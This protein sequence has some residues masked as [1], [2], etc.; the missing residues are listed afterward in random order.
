MSHPHGRPRPADLRDPASRLAYT[1][2][3]ANNIDAEL[4]GGPASTHAA[5]TPN[6]APPPKASAIP[7]AQTTF[8]GLCEALNTMQIDLVKKGIYTYPNT[9]SIEFKASPSGKNIGESAVKLDGTVAHAQTAMADTRQAINQKAQSVD[10]RSKKTSVVAGTSILQVIDKVIR[11][12]QYIVDQAKIVV[13]ADGKTQAQVPS[14]HPVWYNVIMGAVQTQF[15]PKRND[16]AYDI[17]FLITPFDISQ[18][19]S[20]YFPRGRFRGVHKEYDYWFTGKNTEVIGFDQILNT[21]WFTVIGQN[22]ATTKDTGYDV[23]NP[24]DIRRRL[25]APANSVAD[26]G[27]ERGTEAGASFASALFTAND[28]S[29]ANI[30]ILGDPAWLVA[31]EAVYGANADAFEFEPFNADGSINSSASQILFTINW[32]T[33][34]DYNLDTGLMQVNSANKNKNISQAEYSVIYT[35]IGTT[36]TFSKGKFTQDLSGQLYREE[37]PSPPAKPAAP[38]ATAVTTVRVPD[39]PKIRPAGQVGGVGAAGTDTFVNTPGGAATGMTKSDAKLEE[40]AKGTG[41]IAVAAQREIDRRKA[42]G[43][44][45]QNPTANVI[46]PADQAAASRITPAEA[47]NVLDNG[48]PADIRFYGGKAALEERMKA[49]K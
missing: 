33:M 45:G 15:D 7:R 49:P 22:A 18:I 44:W 9:Y 5:E 25:F 42:A 4:T 37:Y 36:S 8:T 40:D 11:N 31:T 20:E 32:N 14:G 16:Y 26:Q 23:S 21:N 28:F 27:S 13:T 24:N 41:G 6:A 38:T 17:K 29:K 1:Y 48:G 2:G 35:T 3:S 10:T 43:T 47:K 46:P 19:D 30:K 39:A 34:Q 12:S